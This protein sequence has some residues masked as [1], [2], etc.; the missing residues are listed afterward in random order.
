MK[1]DPLKSK[2]VKL[3]QNKDGLMSFNF[4][5]MI[6][7]LIFLVIVLLAVVI[8]V[9]LFVVER[10][11]FDPLI[12]DVFSHSLLYSPGGVSYHDPLTGRVYPGTIHADQFS[13]LDLNSS[14][15]LGNNRL[16]AAE[17]RLKTFAYNDKPEVVGFPTV[18]YNK[19]WYDNWQP[20]AKWNI[21]GLSGADYYIK[22]LPVVVHTSH[23]IRRGE[24]M[25]KMI[26][27]RS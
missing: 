8:L 24:L 1:I 11:S 16:I 19:E 4:I 17:I 14:L 15:N 7:R 3:L 12:A 22:V 20:L 5:A 23:G 13:D 9:R 10:F 26:I 6:P 18:Y 27:P 25:I 21:P 2:T